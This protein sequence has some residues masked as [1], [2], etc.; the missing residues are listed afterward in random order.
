MRFPAAPVLA[1]ALVIAIP[2]W[3][4]QI[5]DTAF[6]PTVAAP[7]YAAG[8]GPVVLIDEGHANFHTMEGRYLAFARL[9]QRDGYVVRPHGGRFTRS[10]LEAARILV[11]ANAMHT[12]DPGGW[13]L[14]KE[15][16]FDTA[17][18]AAVREWV[19]GGGS[20]LLI[21]DHMPFPGA[22]ESLAAEFG[23]MMSNGFAMDAAEEDGGFMFRRADGS[24]A[25]HPVTEGRIARERID[26]VAAFT[27]Q[28]FRLNRG[29]SA[30]MTLGQ[31]TML[32]MPVVA[33]QF[34]PL[35]PRMRADGMLQG[36]LLEF[37]R[38]RVA[39]FGEAAMFTAQ[40]SGPDRSPMGMNHPVAPQNAQFL[41]N[42][43]RWLGRLL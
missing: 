3:A 40:V 4:Q 22:A 28:A 10:S 25:A 13:H 38:G 39:V 19:R 23:I 5:A 32:L 17:E 11:I 31:G 30:L 43:L 20:L 15:S 24:L 7:A 2:A 26:S 1:V 8:R 12:P 16:A 34:S 27:G 9:L 21:A 18:I 36:A 35:T 42:V 6:R 29:G 37:G 14:P 41:L 33:W